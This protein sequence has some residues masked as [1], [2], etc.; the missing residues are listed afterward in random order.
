MNTATEADGTEFILEVEGVRLHP[1]LQA[2]STMRTQDWSHDDWRMLAPAVLAV[3]VL[4]AHDASDRGEPENAGT[5]VSGHPILSVAREDGWACI[6]AREAE[7]P[8]G[9]STAEF[10]LRRLLQREGLEVGQRALV[11]AM[12]KRLLLENDR[13]ATASPDASAEDV[14]RQAGVEAARAGGVSRGMVIEAEEP[15]H[16]APDLAEKVLGGQCELHVASGLFRK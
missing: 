16:G 11:A 1:A 9:M 5:L 2:L 10:V 13:Q 6:R 4:S 8:D 14:N 12:L 15:L 7:I 3:E